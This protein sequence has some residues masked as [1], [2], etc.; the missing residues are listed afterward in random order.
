V[1]RLSELKG[2]KIR[3]WMLDVLSRRSL[4]KADGCFQFPALTASPTS[5]T[6]SSPLCAPKPI[7]PVLLAFAPQTA[8]GAKAPH[9]KPHC[10]PL[11]ATRVPAHGNASAKSVPHVVPCD[12]RS[13]HCGEFS[14]KRVPSP[15][16]ATSPPRG[17]P[18]KARWQSP[19]SLNEHHV[20][21][22]ECGA[23]PRAQ[24]LQLVCSP[25]FPGAHPGAL[26]RLFFYPAY[27]LTFSIK[28]MLSIRVRL[29]RF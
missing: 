20:S 9:A 21:P 22:H 29:S 23:S 1:R 19:A 17:A 25:I 8:P 27:I 12:K 4:T 14:L 15:A 16:A 28:T 24:I 2:R 26:V 6:S 11:A 5:A 10:A 7:A 13:S 3:C 18:R